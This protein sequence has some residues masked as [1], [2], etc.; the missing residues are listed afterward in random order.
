MKTTKKPAAG[1][2]VNKFDTEL[3]NIL[4]N[5]LQLFVTNTRLKPVV[6]SVPVISVP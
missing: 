1:K 4:L 2:L 3:K 5:D 6:A